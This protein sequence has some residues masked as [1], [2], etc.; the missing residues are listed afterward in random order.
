MKTRARSHSQGNAGANCSVGRVPGQ[1][2]RNDGAEASRSVVMP[3]GF[4]HVAPWLRIAICRE[5]QP[6]VHF[7]RQFGAASRRPGRNGLDDARASTK[8]SWMTTVA[9]ALRGAVHRLRVL[10]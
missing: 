2:V 3:G 9:R 7:A 5:V 8:L 6:I 4:G 10:R 1:H